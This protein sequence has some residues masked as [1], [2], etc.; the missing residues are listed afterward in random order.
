[1]KELGLMPPKIKR[2]TNIEKADPERVRRHQ[3]AR[4]EQ[5][6]FI[7]RLALQHG[8]MYPL[9]AF[10]HSYCTE[11]LVLGEDAVTVAVLMRHKDTTMIS[12]HYAHLTQHQE[13]LKR[14]VNRRRESEGASE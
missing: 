13:H 12:R 6:Q 14:A 10:R 9:Y 4:K 5:R 1:M 8:T 2:L 7:H 11:L 3:H